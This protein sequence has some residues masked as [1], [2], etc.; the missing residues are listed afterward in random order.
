[1]TV[2]MHGH[3]NAGEKVRNECK[4]LGN[5]VGVNSLTSRVD[6]PHGQN[7]PRQ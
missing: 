3:D 5:T 1:M 4:K 6:Y 2:L 7:V